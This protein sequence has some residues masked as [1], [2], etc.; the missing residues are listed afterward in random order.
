MELVQDTQR[1][2][3]SKEQLLELAEK[4][5]HDHTG[6]KFYKDPALVS[7]LWDDRNE[8]LSIRVVSDYVG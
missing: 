8:S 3:L 7:L 6:K 1:V 5:Y 4:Y 2:I